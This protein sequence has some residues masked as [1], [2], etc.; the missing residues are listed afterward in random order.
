[1]FDNHSLFTSDTHFNQLRAMEKSRRPFETVRQMDRTMIH[2]LN[3]AGTVGKSTVYHVGDFGDYAAVKEIKHPIVLICGNYEY[4]DINRS[5][6]SDF[7]RFKSHLISLGF[8]DVVRETLTDGDMFLNHF[9]S[10]QDQTKFNL[11]GHV[12]QLRMVT[13]Y[14]LNVGVDCHYYKPATMETVKYYRNGVENIFDK[15]VFR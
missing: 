12:H 13:P 10:M 15:E 9:P 8:K 11:F 1:M 14:G 4:D 2:N 5:F 3:V 6:G 7:E